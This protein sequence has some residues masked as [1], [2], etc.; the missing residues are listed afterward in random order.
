MDIMAWFRNFLNAYQP[1]GEWNMTVDWAVRTCTRLWDRTGDEVCRAHVIT[2]ADRLIA[3]GACQPDNAKALFFALQETG[4]EKY[5]EA[6]E[7][8]MAQMG[9]SPQDTMLSAQ[10]LYAC[11]P[12]RM[13][14]EMKLGGMEKVGLCAGKFRQ[15]HRALLDDESGLIVG[16]LRDTAI[17]LL[18]LADAIELCADQLYEHWRAMVDIYR[19]VLRGALAAKAP[20]EPETAAMIVS[21]LHAGVRMKL[22][23]P[24]RYLPIARKRIT[25]L[26]SAG[27]IR[28][29][30][31]LELEG[32]ML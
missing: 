16:S 22:I 5:R 8:V 17:M 6:I 13:A 20:A 11:L 18:A 9:R 32:G 4:A 31:M 2:W 23:D 27:H 15:S 1:G 21:A 28:A 25:D 3:N 12:F 10:A 7:R 30:A 14:Y 19:A 26:A 24:E 29:A